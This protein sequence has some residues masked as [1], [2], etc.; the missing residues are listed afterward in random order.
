MKLGIM[1]LFHRWGVELCVVR[2]YVERILD[3]PRSGKL[4][5]LNVE[6]EESLKRRSGHNSQFSVLKFKY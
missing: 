5:K 2:N 6:K 1:H 4:N 3:K